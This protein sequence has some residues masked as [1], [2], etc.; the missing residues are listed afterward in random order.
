MIASGLMLV[1][2]ERNS[3]LVL[4]R[5]GWVMGRLSLRA[6]CFTGEET[7]SRPRPLG[8]SGW[9]TTRW[10]RWPAAA[11]FSSA[12]TA[13]GGVPQKMRDKDMWNLVIGK[14]GNWVIENL[15][16]DPVGFQLHNY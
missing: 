13:K 8:R 3:S 5:S 4:M 2:W 11:S 16:S 15:K 10:I 6:D 7:S 12:G 14:F 1:S 9:V